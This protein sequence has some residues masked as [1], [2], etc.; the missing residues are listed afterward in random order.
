M[1]KS[2]KGKVGQRWRD[3]CNMVNKVG[4]FVLQY[5][6]R[7]T[8]AANGYFP[9]LLPVIGKATINERTFIWRMEFGVPVIALGEYE[10]R[11]RGCWHLA[12]K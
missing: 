5:E 9:L 8:L 7:T 4:L 6:D 1:E 12:T 2:R 3:Q 10:K 11:L